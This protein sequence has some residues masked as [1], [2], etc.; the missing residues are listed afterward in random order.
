[1][2]QHSFMSYYGFIKYKTNKWRANGVFI[3][4]LS[5]QMIVFLNDTSKCS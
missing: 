3:N 4:I 1:M 5:K 2:G